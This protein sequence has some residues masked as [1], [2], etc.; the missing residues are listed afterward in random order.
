MIT[1]K[2]KTSFYFS[3]MDSIRQRNSLKNSIKFMI[4]IFPFSQNAKREIDLGRRKKDQRIH[5]EVK[6]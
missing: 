6:M 5:R 2:G 1:M 4:S 3:E